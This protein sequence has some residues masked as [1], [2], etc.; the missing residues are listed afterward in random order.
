MKVAMVYPN[1]DFIFPLDLLIIQP[2]IIR[3]LQY[4]RVSSAPAQRQVNRS[5]QNS[6]DTCS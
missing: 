5:K 2:S 6:L 1:S 3:P 4:K